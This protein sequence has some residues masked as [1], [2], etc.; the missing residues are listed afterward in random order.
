VNYAIVADVV[1]YVGPGLAFIAYPAAVAEMPVS[2]LWSIMFFF[3]VILLGLDSEVFRVACQENWQLHLKKS[4][5]EKARDS[6]LK[7]NLVSF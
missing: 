7:S 6:V 5:L 4:F 2:P 3:M 1:H